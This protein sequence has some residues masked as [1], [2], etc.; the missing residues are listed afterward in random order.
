MQVGASTVVLDWWGW[1]WGSY[2]LDGWRLLL[3]WE[4][5][6]FE[7]VLEVCKHMLLKCLQAR[8]CRRGCC[9]WSWGILFATD[10]A[11]SEA[12]SCTQMGL[13]YGDP[14]LLLGGDFA[15]LG[16]CRDVYRGLVYTRRT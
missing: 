4:Y 14:V 10:T 3:I 5:S 2:F 15:S 9:G 7:T 12:T 13:S 16:I 6:V 11:V 1:C 8:L